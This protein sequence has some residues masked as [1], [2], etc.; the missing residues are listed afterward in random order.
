MVSIA[1]SL[2]LQYSDLDGRAVSRKWKLATHIHRGLIYNDNDPRDSLEIRYRREHSLLTVKGLR[3]EV[4]E[5]KAERQYPETLTA[6][7]VDRSGL[8][9]K[10]SSG[11]INDD[12]NLSASAPRLK[13]RLTLHVDLFR[14]SLND[15]QH[16]GK[17][18]IKTA[19]TCLTKCGR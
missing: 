11:F 5:V 1:R 4:G 19:F 14:Y 13:R 8:G 15:P 18:V 16:R 9:Q 3:I 7:G 17:W 6:D 10:R 12:L 2:L